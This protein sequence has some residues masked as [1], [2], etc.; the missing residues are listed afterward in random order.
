MPASE[1]ES[2]SSIPMQAAGSP[3]SS[4]E[5]AEK[6]LRSR[7]DLSYL[8]FDGVE[9]ENVVARLSVANCEHN[10]FGLQSSWFLDRINCVYP[11]AQNR[12]ICERNHITCEWA[13]QETLVCQTALR[14]NRAALNSHGN[15]VCLPHLEITVCICT[16]GLNIQTVFHLLPRRIPRPWGREGMRERFLAASRC[17]LSYIANLFRLIPTSTVV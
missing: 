9:I 7:A 16:I 1:N 2:L 17:D 3:I 4:Q 11:G 6:I 14:G 13:V 8:F 10:R 12:I 15:I 5:T